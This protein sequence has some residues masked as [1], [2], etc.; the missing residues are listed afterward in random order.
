MAN[1]IN[2]DDYTH[3]VFMYKKKTQSDFV[4]MLSGYDVRYMNLG[5]DAF[6]NPCALPKGIKPKMWIEIFA[7]N[8]TEAYDLSDASRSLI[9]GAL[10]AQ[11]KNMGV[12]S[13]YFF[14]DKQG[15]ETS[16]KVNMQEVFS[17]LLDGK[18]SLRE[19][20][21]SQAT[22]NLAYQ[23]LL[24]ALKVFR[25]RQSLEYVSTCSDQAISLS[26]L[27]DVRQKTITVLENYSYSTFFLTLFSLIM[28][29]YSENE[30]VM[31]NTLF[32]KE[33]SPEVFPLRSEF[34]MEKMQYM[35]MYAI[36]KSIPRESAANYD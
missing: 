35:T 25:D 19:Q 7:K 30:H 20:G 36:D 29:C 21:F 10:N 1:K 12:F 17:Y 8:F 5:R 3:I 13:A 26:S 2:F 15:L 31:E 23:E 16:L 27:L 14:S 32:I 33:D 22:I 24:T 18:I 6:L 11:Y 34:S 9:N 28:A 4:D